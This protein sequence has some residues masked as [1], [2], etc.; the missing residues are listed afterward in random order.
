MSIQS[1]FKEELT[2][3]STNYFIFDAGYNKEYDD[4]DFKQYQYCKSRYNQVKE[5]DVFIYRKPSSTS[6]TKKF[7]FF[8]A[9]KISSI[10]GNDKLTA[11]LEKVY[12]FQNDLYQDDLNNFRWKW[13][14][15]GAT[16]EHFFNQYGMNKITKDD[17][18]NLINMSEYDSDVDYDPD[19]AKDTIRKIKSKNFS[20][21]DHFSTSKIRSGQQA[22]ANIVKKN[23][24]NRCAICNISTKVFLEASHIVS[25]KF[26]KNIRLDP[27]N[28]ICLCKLHHVAFDSGYLTID[29]SY[30]ILISDNV[31]NDPSLEDILKKYH[32][33]KFNLP[34]SNKPKIK[35]LKFH[36]NKIFK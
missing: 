35:Y 19:I 6:E 12:T 29:D 2:T 31:Q 18:V 30:Q 11:T 20:V 25:W 7:Y 10:T 34:N 36:G 14:K 33:T 3:P 15:K 13:K 28:A 8:G 4:L 16:W 1:F 21:E 17:F 32:R 22:F 23:Y 24:N 5:K 26:D 9:C 27:S